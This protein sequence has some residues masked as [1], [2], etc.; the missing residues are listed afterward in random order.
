MYSKTINKES[1]QRNI[2]T[3]KYIRVCKK[4]FRLGNLYFK[5][6]TQRRKNEK[7]RDI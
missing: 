3:S 2:K 1:I 4:M 7:R 6:K 5:A